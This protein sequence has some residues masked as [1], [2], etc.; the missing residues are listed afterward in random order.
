MKKLLSTLIL[1]LPILATLYYSWPKYFDEG[2]VGAGIIILLYLVMVSWISLDFYVTN[3]YLFTIFQLVR[4]L[5]IL[6]VLLSFVFV[7]WEAGRDLLI[8]VGVIAGLGVLFGALYNLFEE[9]E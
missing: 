6:V 3:P 7:L 5:C 2:L 8:V 4:C 9:T 1:S